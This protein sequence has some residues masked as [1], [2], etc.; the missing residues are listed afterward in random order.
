M[1]RWGHR[2]GQ[3]FRALREPRVLTSARTAEWFSLWQ[4]LAQLPLVVGVLALVIEWL[5]KT[6]FVPLVRTS[7][8][9]LKRR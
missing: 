9:A 1:H 8:A 3:R 5:P 7:A 4:H 2:H 6:D